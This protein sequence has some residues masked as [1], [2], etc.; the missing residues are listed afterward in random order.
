L[1]P[2]ITTL[3]FIIGIS[4]SEVVVHIYS[5]E[6]LILNAYKIFIGKPEWKRQPGPAS[7]LMGA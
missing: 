4:I 5:T 1:L 6:R 7:M 2:G 3:N